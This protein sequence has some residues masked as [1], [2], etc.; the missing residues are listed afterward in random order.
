MVFAIT[1]F[2]VYNAESLDE[3]NKSMNLELKKEDFYFVGP[4]QVV[5]LTSR[6]VDFVQDRKQ[7]SSIMFHNFFRKDSKPVLFFAIQVAL[8]V[9][10]L[11]CCLGT[12]NYIKDFLATIS[13][14]GV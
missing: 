4:D 6:D 14:G 5:K 11:F 12:Y 7:L 13:V 9:C 10:N 8:L 2:G 1:D 3:L